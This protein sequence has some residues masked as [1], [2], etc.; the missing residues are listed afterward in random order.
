VG[1]T[2]KQLENLPEYDDNS[3]IDYNYEEKVRDIYRSPNYEKPVYDQNSYSYDLDGDLYTTNS[4]DH[5]IIKLYEEKLVAN[6]KRKKVGE[7]NIGK[8]VETERTRVSVPVETERIVINRK[9]PTNKGQKINP[10]ETDFQEGE[11]ARIELYQETA[12]IKKEAFV[13][14][15]VEIKKEVEKDSLTAEETLRKE[16]LEINVDGKPVI[17]E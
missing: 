8:R 5:G 9:T 2:K 17:N 1:L 11:I 13:S 12:K 14:E 3:V 10:H 6:K 7:V 15:E 16:K 4:A